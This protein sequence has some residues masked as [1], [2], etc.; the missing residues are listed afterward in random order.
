MLED[1]RNLQCGRCLAVPGF[2]V[3]DGSHLLRARKNFLI[4]LF[5][6]P[7][8]MKNAGFGDFSLLFTD[9]LGLFTVKAGI[10]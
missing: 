2:R 1:R 4:Y 6:W 7:L 3:F 9:A 10:F 8:V 5:F